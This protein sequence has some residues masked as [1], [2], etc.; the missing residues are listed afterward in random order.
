MLEISYNSRRQLLLRS[1][2]VLCVF[3]REMLLVYEL[4]YNSYMKNPYMARKS[5]PIFI[6]DIFH[7]LG[8]PKREDFEGRAVHKNWPI[9]AV[10]QQDEQTYLSWTGITEMTKVSI[11]LMIVVRLVETRLTLISS[12][13][14]GSGHS[15]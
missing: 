6:K 15:C 4:V 5:A 7:R 8:T 1:R 10:P 14:Y 3:S 2:C 12:A 9:A 13:G 11:V